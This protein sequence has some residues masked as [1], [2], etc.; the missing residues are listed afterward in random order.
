V[1]NAIRK[2]VNLEHG[3]TLSIEVPLEMGN[4]VELIVIS[5]EDELTEAG[6]KLSEDEVFIVSSYSAAIE[7]DSEEDKVWERYLHVG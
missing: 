2:I 5:C 3:R 1:S 6:E 7:D 4:Y